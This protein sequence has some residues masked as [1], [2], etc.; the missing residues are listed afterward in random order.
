MRKNFTQFAMTEGTICWIDGWVITKPTT[1]K[2]LDL[3]YKYIDMMIGDQVQ[4]ELAKLIGFGIVNP[5]GGEG[6]SPVIK[7][8]YLW[9]Q[10]INEFPVA[11][12]HHGARGGPGQA[13]GAVEQSEGDAVS[14][15]VVTGCGRGRSRR[16]VPPSFLQS[17]GGNG[18]KSTRSS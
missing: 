8:S 18:Q 15:R 14:G 4:N 6:F 17:G 3:A 12:G 9:Y 7:D 13:R 10:D 5:A 1:G 16:G 11:A 2:S